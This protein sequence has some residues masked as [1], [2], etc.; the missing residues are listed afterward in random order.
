MKARHLQESWQGIFVIESDDA[1]SGY[2]VF[3][4]RSAY[5]R[6]A[7][8]EKYDGGFLPEI[9]KVTCDELDKSSGWLRV[10]DHE[11]VKRCAEEIAFEMIKIEN[12]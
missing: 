10:T 1:K 12:V 2:F 6:I 8:K 4:Y 5:I 11:D 9:I 3:E 7:K